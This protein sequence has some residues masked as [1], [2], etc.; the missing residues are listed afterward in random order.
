[1]TQL[2]DPAS[3]SDKSE[4][5]PLPLLAWGRF[6]AVAVGPLLAIC[7]WRSKA[8]VALRPLQ[9]GMP[10][11]Q[12]L[13]P[14]GPEGV[15]FGLV[16]FFAHRAF[17]LEITPLRGVSLLALLAYVAI[18]ML[19]WGLGAFAPG[20]MVLGPF[21][22]HLTPLRDVVAYGGL[23]GMIIAAPVAVFLAGL[24]IPMIFVAWGFATMVGVIA[25]PTMVALARTGGVA[26]AAS[27]NGGSALLIVPCAGSAFWLVQIMLLI[28]VFDH[29]AMAARGHRDR[30]HH[31][32]IRR[33]TRAGHPQARARG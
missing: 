30:A 28:F 18:W 4:E 25:A 32:R 27:L 33:A 17:D 6:G 8:A 3:A 22:E 14:W 26:N 24:A 11:L 2:P 7:V 1:M 20:W 15:V 12:L 13:K 5:V 31:R 29:A 19:I 23:G 21:A 9:F 16:A 10:M